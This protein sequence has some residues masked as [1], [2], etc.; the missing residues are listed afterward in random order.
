G[1]RAGAGW[2]RARPGRLR[3]CSAVVGLTDDSRRGQPDQARRP[4]T[5]PR[6]PLRG[7]GG[8]R[9]GPVGAALPPGGGRGGQLRAVR[10]RA[11]GGG[12]RGRGGNGGMGLIVGLGLLL[13]ITAP[14][15]WGR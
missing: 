12:R 4:G 5:P 11:S 2:R 14:P 7:G 9:A 3:P 1:G 8:R 6:A 10:A 15:A 13:R